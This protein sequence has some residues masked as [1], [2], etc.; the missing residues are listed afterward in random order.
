MEVLTECVKDNQFTLN[1]T[2]D[3]NVVKRGSI[4]QKE[5]TH[6]KSGMATRV[7]GVCHTLVYKSLISSMD[8]LQIVLREEPSS[9]KIYLHDPNFF[10]QK[11][12]SY[13]IPFVLLDNP[14]GEQYK[15]VTSQNTRMN[16]PGIFSCKEDT[17]YNFNKCVAN[18][19]ATKLGCRFPW[20]SDQT[21]RR[22]Q[23][24][25]TTEKVNEYWKTY[26]ILYMATQQHLETQTGCQ[27]P[28]RYNHYS[29]VGKPASFDIMNFTFISL[30]FAS[31]DLTD[32]QEVGII[33]IIIIIILY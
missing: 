13:F 5:N 30:S 2:I 23:I 22:F 20:A 4:Y 31:T 15:I 17:D 6:W 1:D 8:M 27:V 21:N 25:N 7:L 9:Y 33:I 14:K 24:C 29:V 3:T 18:S 26:D 32:I 28:C 19:L 16:R 11:S 10:L 12:D